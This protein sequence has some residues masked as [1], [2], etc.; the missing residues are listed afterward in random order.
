MNKIC[1]QKISPPTH[2]KK[3]T[4]TAIQKQPIKNL[5]KI[6]CFF[7]ALCY[8]TSTKLQRVTQRQAFNKYSAHFYFTPS[9]TH[10]YAFSPRRRLF[11]L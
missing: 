6:F 3:P 9:H 1:I 2:L 5:C 11:P 4:I 10:T 7:S 8:H